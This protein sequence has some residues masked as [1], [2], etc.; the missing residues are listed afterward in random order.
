MNNLNAQVATAA[1]A[2][3]FA[4]RGDGSVVSAQA[5]NQA[6]HATDRILGIASSNTERSDQMARELRSWQE[7]QVAK[8]MAFNSAEAQ[9][10]RDWQERMSN[11]A[12]QREV[13]DLIAA[14][15]NPVLSANGGNGASVGSGAS[16]SV[17]TPSGA[18]GDVDT[19][20]SSGMAS[21]L[22]SMFGL[23]A[24]LASTGLSA[25]NNMAIAEKNNAISRFLGQLQSDTQLRATA[26]N[27][28][29]ARYGYDT[30]AAAS[31]YASDLGYAGQK[32]QAEKTPVGAIESLL[33]TATGES[34]LGGAVKSG[35]GNLANKAKNG[36]FYAFGVKN[37]K[38]LGDV[39][40]GK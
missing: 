9:K 23:T 39:L 8:T 28:A 21:V 4:Q 3:N 14:G 6:A 31:R 35:V 17:A 19:S 25:A 40:L 36:L 11:T 32:L 38:E 29:T 1:S 37:W 16:A 2:Q 5:A 7:E 20:A 12:H 13:A 24:S 30:S 34:T 22:S 26:M 18:K 27:N 33:K 15:L 10:N